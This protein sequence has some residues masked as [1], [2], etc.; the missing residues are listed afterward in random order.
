MKKYNWD[1]GF[2]RFPDYE[3]RAGSIYF[4]VNL[5]E[6]KRPLRL[7]PETPEEL[8]ECRRQV[9]DRPDPPIGSLTKEKVK[10]DGIVYAAAGRIAGEH[11]AHKQVRVMV[12][13]NN[14]QG[15]FVGVRAKYVS[16]FCDGSKETPW[17]DKFL[18][19]DFLVAIAEQ[20]PA[21]QWFDD[22]FDERL[23]VIHQRIKDSRCKIAW[24]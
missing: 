2:A 19:A 23:R 24:D 9:V 16:A 7:Y 5:P 20:P 22:D 1:Y 12:D 21:P 3:A 8:E 4:D 13:T 18:S 10:F 14:N 17:A 6:L 15:I 11:G